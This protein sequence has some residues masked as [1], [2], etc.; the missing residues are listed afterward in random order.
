V[1]T[2]DAQAFKMQAPHLALE[3]GFDFLAG[4]VRDF[5]FP[6]KRYSLFI[7]GAT[8][9]A[10]ETFRGE[11]P[12]RKFDT[13]VAGTRRILDFAVHCEAKRFLFLSS[14]VAYGTQPAGMDFI[15]EEYAG[16]PDTMDADTALGQAKRAAEYLCAYYARAHGLDYSVA[17]CFSFVGPFLPLDIHYA[18]GNFIGQALFEDEITVKGDGSPLRSYLYMADLV[19][20]L[21]TLLIRGG[22][23]QIYNVGSD[24]VV[25]I[26]EL[27]HLVR[28]IVS[29]Q[30][31]VNVLGQSTYSVGNA[32]R[33]LYVPNINKAR[34]EAQL[35]VWTRLPDAIRFTASH[36]LQHFP[37][38][39]GARE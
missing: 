22:N 20:W 6:A 29:P 38:N 37:H 13:L 23:A 31:I 39:N 9:S 14:G 30:K 3:P 7:H 11:D 15:P 33:N 25:S 2:R 26:R 16:A 32:V 35:E 1:L 12:L 28:D 21:L 18:I 8:T 10:G 17:R 4:D 5:E 36:V 24:Q 27:A 19:S 34:N